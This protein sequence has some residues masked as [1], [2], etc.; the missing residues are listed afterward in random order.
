MTDKAIQ[1]AL[2]VIGIM[3]ELPRE[4]QLKAQGVLLG[5]KLA[6]SGQ[7]ENMT[8]SSGQKGGAA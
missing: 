8:R 5:M 7:A 1:E 2:E 6:A 4:E 3:Q